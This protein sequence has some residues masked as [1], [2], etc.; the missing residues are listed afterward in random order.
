MPAT[1]GVTVTVPVE[2]LAEEPPPAEKTAMK[3]VCAGESVPTSRVATP[4]ETV[5]VPRSVLPS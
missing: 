4:S 5:E 1:V 3:A 2:P